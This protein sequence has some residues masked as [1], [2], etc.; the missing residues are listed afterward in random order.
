[1]Y[2]FPHEPSWKHHYKALAQQLL[3]VADIEFH[4]IGSTSI[5]NLNAKN[6][7][8]IL[9]VVEDFEVGRLLIKP[10]EALGYKYKGEY[11]I[12]GRHYFS[13]AGDT[14][15][16]LH[17]LPVGH[18][19]IN[20][21]LHFKDVMTENSGLIEEFNDLKQSLSSQFSKDVYQQ[22]KAVFYEKII[23]LEHPLSLKQ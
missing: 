4:H 1:M 23:A 21:H 6:C 15:V 5:P 13:K 14:K 12:A 19:Q 20:M 17:V 8:D 10:F 7:I 22:K 16:H 3:G 11:G 18:E 2:I 9:G